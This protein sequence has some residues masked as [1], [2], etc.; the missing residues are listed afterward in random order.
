MSRI[1]LGRKDVLNP[2]EAI[3]HF[4]L[5]RRKFYELIKQDGLKFM[6]YYGER[7]LIIRTEFE[8]YLLQHPELRRME[9][10]WPKKR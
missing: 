9:S 6:A 2:Q 5:S 10:G 4:V 3:E 7:K 8:K 1:D